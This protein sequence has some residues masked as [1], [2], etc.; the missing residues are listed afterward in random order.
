M[1]LLMGKIGRPGSAPFQFAGQPSSMNTRESGADGTYPAYRN[2]EDTA[3]MKD[4]AQ[5]WNVPRRAAR[6]EAGVGAGDL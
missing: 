6:Q 5:R 1:H 4:L 2:W 3:H